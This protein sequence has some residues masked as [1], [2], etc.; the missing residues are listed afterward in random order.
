MSVFT[1]VKERAVDYMATKHTN[2]TSAR[3]MEEAKKEVSQNK[4]TRTRSTQTVQNK[5]STTRYQ[6]E[7]E[8][9][10]ELVPELSNELVL[11][12]T[13]IV[14]VLLFLSNFRLSGTVGEVIN[15]FTFGLFGVLAYVIPFILFLGVAF[16]LANRFSNRRYII[17]LLASIGL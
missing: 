4:G 12:V 7:E 5:N 17:K 8:Y 11:L 1:F 14:S 15:Q 9:E 13:L 16:Y 10:E 3:K 6:L 2:T